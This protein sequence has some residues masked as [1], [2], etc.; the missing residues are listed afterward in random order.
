L[1]C[2]VGDELRDGR[3]VVQILE[4]HLVRLKEQRGVLARLAAGLLR[5]LAQLRDGRI[6]GL[7]V[8]REL[9]F[10]VRDLH[11]LHDGLLPAVKADGAA[12]DAGGHAGSL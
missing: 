3:D 4:H 2:S 6:R 12:G 7:A 11:A 5:E 1:T 10:R 9:L 8:A